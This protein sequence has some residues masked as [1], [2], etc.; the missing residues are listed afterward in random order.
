MASSSDITVA[1][2][3]KLA[4][5]DVDKPIPEGDVAAVLSNPPFLRI[6]GTFNTRD[7]GR[8]PGSPIRPSYAFR[9][10]MLECSGPNNLAALAQTHGIKW[11]FDLRSEIEQQQSPDPD[12]MGTRKVWIPNLHEEPVDVR[13]FISG[14]G[15]EGYR[16]MYMNI[17]G[18]YGP[19]FRAILEHVRDRPEEPFLFHCT[20]KHS[21]ELL[22]RTWRLTISK[23]GRDRTGIAAGLLMSLAGGS[24]ETVALD[25]MLTRL[26]SEP[27][28]E[29][30]LTRALL[31]TGCE[32]IEAPGFYNL[33]SLRMT[34]WDAFLKELQSVYGGFEGYVTSHLGFSKNEVEQI[35]KNLQ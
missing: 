35:K 31:E 25:Y 12:I 15:E 13:D 2:L 18:A 33:C 4:E 16:K 30:L 27:V 26:G 19:S 6:S 14:D 21:P 5:T 8:V 10:G 22:V 17:M 32:D 11:V 24:A 9:S 23:V 34:S 20:C 3:L 29:M 28:H 7:L 1:Q